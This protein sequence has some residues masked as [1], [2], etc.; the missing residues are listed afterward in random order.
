MR[1]MVAV[2][3]VAIS[4]SGQRASAQDRKDEQDRHNLERAQAMEASR[5]HCTLVRFTGIAVGGAPINLEAVR[6]AEDPEDLVAR[7]PLTCGPNALTQTYAC[8]GAAFLLERTAFIVN[9]SKDYF[10]VDR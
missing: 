8:H 9:W 1:I 7:N 3:A 5:P 2:C 4:L 10:Q 6:H